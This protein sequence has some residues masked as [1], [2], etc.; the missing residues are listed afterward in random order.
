MNKIQLEIDI[1]EN[2][3]KIRDKYV[4]ISIVVNKII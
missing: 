1:Q 3:N 4:Y 2:K